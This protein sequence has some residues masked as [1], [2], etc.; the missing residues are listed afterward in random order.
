[1]QRESN[2]QQ[3]NPQTGLPVTSTSGAQ[4]LFQIMPG[5]ARGRDITS[6]TGNINTGLDLFNQYSAKYKGKGVG[7]VSDLVLIDMAMVMGEG[8]TDQFL[9]GS[10]T[11][12]D[13][14]TSKRADI[15]HDT[16]F[17]VT[18]FLRI[19]PANAAPQCK[20]TGGCGCGSGRR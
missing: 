19:E 15:A 3:I 16:G 5:T 1:M 13:L 10:K 7:G 17:N 9:A 2:F 11:L 4:G 20:P 8:F 6:A 18:A 12:A 14:S